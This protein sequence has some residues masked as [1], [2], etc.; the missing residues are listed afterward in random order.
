MSTWGTKDFHC[1]TMHMRKY[2]IHVIFSHIAWAIWLINRAQR[3]GKARPC[4]AVLALQSKPA[5]NQA[6]THYTF[7]AG[8]R[9]LMDSRLALQH[10]FCVTWAVSRPYME[11]RPALSCFWRVMTS[12]DASAVALG[13][14]RR[15]SS[16][17]VTLGCFRRACR[18]TI[19]WTSC[20]SR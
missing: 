14:F 20:P 3:G 8:F 13:C 2:P 6:A 18:K 5:V 19:W 12:P 7:S 10:Q 17:A 16:C 15:A 4:H 9:G 1:V 11:L